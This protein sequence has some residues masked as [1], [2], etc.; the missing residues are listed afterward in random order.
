MP[1]T[2]P[3]YNLL[4]FIPCSLTKRCHSP[5]WACVLREF[6]QLP[7]PSPGPAP[8]PH[9]GRR[10]GEPAEEGAGPPPRTLALGPHRFAG[11]RCARALRCGSHSR[12]DL[13]PK[14]S[15][16]KTAASSTNDAP[17]ASSTR[18]AK[19]RSGVY[20]GP[21]LPPPASGARRAA[22]SPQ[23]CRYAPAG[24]R[25]EFVPTRP[26]QD[27]TRGG[28]RRAGC[29]SAALKTSTTA[30]PKDGVARAAGRRDLNFPVS[31]H[32]DWL[33]RVYAVCPLADLKNTLGG[34]VIG[35]RR[36]EDS[37]ARYGSGRAIP[38]HFAVRRGRTPDPS[39]QRASSL[40]CFGPNLGSLQGDYASDVARCSFAWAAASTKTPQM[41]SKMIPFKNLDIEEVD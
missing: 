19:A 34:L 13:K 14:H 16:R 18:E 7:P 29:R 32:S 4:A 24:L 39:M 17:G 6:F 28:A 15:H 36:R 12:G 40:P 20:S 27:S 31:P 26:A 3:P 8:A 38:E 37:I 25:P 22:R 11:P 21:P 35:P 33:V 5:P 30:Q 23:A 10:S 2:S 9:P 1:S 41:I